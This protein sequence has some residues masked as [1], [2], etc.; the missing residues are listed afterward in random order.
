MPEDQDE[1]LHCESAAFMLC[2]R[3]ETL[4]VQYQEKVKEYARIIAQ[5]I[6]VDRRL[7]ARHAS[8]H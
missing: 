5:R 6:L 7:R 8:S 1:C 4:D 2:I 3:C